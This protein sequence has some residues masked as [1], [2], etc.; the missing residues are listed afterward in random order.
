MLGE[1]RPVR[2]WHFLMPKLLDAPI[3]AITNNGDFF[4]KFYSNDYLGT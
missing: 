4:E 2:K 1:S 3:V